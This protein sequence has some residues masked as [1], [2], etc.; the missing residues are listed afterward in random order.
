[1][2]APTF[3]HKAPVPWAIVIAF[4]SIYIGW[5]TTY[6]AIRWGVKD[7]HWP[8]ALFSGSRVVLAGIILLAVQAARKQPI[9]LSFRDLKSVSVTGA[10]MFIGGNGLLTLAQTTLDSG[11]AAVLASTCPLWIGLLGMLWPDGDRLTPR[12]W[13]GLLVGLVGVILLFA[14]KVN[15][16]DQIFRDVALFC[17][18]GSAASWAL[19]TLL[20]RH[21]R[22]NCSHLTTAGW[23]LTLGGSALVLVGVCCGELHRVPSE[24]TAKAVVA[25]LYLLIVGSLVGFIAYNYLLTH[26]SAAKVGTHSYVNP[27]VAV[28]I[29]CLS[30]EEFSLWLGLSIAVILGGVALVRKGE[31]A[32]RPVTPHRELNA[33]PDVIAA[34]VCEQISVLKR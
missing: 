26:V 2:S 8:P 17:V 6:L 34:D 1:M 28:V 33:R 32:G 13:L 31:T 22:P 16:P 9:G 14:P 4:A 27:V 7:E 29:G 20:A 18:L 24:L 25:F 11:A 5:G 30:G 15:H 10:I 12:G 3:V 19:G 21:R 23:Q